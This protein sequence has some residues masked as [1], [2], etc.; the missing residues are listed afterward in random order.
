MECSVCYCV[1]TLKNI[2][3]TECNH[4]YCK[5]CF[6]KWTK[7]NNNCPMCRTTIV[8][9]NNERVALD[10]QIDH[11]TGSIYLLMDEETQY[12]NSIAFLEN[13]KRELEEDIF[14]LKSFKRDPEGEMKKYMEKRKE[15]FKSMKT[16]IEMKKK[17]VVKQLEGYNM[18]YSNSHNNSF[19][20]KQVLNQIQYEKENNIV[21]TELE[22]VVEMLL[23]I[24]FEY[25]TPTP[26]NEAQS[27]PPIIR[28]RV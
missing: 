17:G 19:N 1:L 6:W 27:P 16:D 22:D 25:T 26:R 20:Y 7:E 11:L 24:D 18:L 28:M 5:D 12:Y 15:Q 23:D 14:K 3:N 8:S 13:E 9:Y 21:D 2:V 4:V 10:E